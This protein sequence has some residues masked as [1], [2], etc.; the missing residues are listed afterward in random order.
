MVIYRCAVTKLGLWLDNYTRVFVSAL[1][2]VEDSVADI[3][4]CLHRVGNC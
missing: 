2:W 4:E 3:N 1:V